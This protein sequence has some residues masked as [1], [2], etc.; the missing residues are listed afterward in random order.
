MAGTYKAF[1]TDKTVENEEGIT[2]DYGEAG[3][4]KIHRAGGANQRFKNYATA[5]TKPYT[6]QM[7][8]NTLDEAV[9]T[10]LQADIFAKTVV[11]GWE[12]VTGRD[13]KEL[14]Y[15]FEN[16]KQLLLD[17]P[18]LFADIQKAAQDASLFRKQ[19]IDDIVGN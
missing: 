16:C 15:N 19:I 10:E 14:P 7:Q 3:K 11:V 12:G 2:L 9:A 5:K 8:Q 1:E 18:D 6:R 13:G 4:F 17:L